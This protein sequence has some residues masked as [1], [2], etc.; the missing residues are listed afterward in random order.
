M[1]SPAGGGAIF[2]G[3]SA[4]Q[5]DAYLTGLG[6]GQ[7]EGKPARQTQQELGI[8]NINPSTDRGVYLANDY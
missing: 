3:M 2:G 8:P 1:R 7:D 5:C 4:M 6:N